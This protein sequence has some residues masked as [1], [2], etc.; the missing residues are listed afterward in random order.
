MP[1]T[2]EQKALMADLEVTYKTPGWA[3]L[4]QGW[5]EEYTSLPETSFLNAK[6]MEDLNADRVRYRFLHELLSL[7]Q[8]LEDAVERAA[9][10]MDEPHNPYE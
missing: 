8:D 9:T 10:G 7:P 2:D 1:L 5:R 4:M 3:R 6:T